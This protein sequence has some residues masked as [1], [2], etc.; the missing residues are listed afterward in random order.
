[1]NTIQ[2]AD[3]PDVKAAIEM[4]RGTDDVYLVVIEPK[5]D[6]IDTATAARAEV[7]AMM[8]TKMNVSALVLV[9]K[10]VT[11]RVFDVQRSG[12]PRS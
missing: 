3:H 12:E 1:M 10:N 11:I 8:L 9:V 2:L 4:K 5:D 6:E 7:L